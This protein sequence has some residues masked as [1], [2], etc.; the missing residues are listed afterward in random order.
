MQAAWALLLK[1]GV[2]ISIDFFGVQWTAFGAI[3]SPLYRFGRSAPDWLGTSENQ[4]P[5]RNV[6][7]ITFIIICTNTACSLSPTP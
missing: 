3:V 2:P 5:W 7:F 1:W 4:G 6:E